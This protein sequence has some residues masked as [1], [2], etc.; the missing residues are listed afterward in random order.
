MTERSSR[1]RRLEDQVARVAQCEGSIGVLSTGEQICV[2]LVLNR[3]DLLPGGYTH[4]LEAVDRLDSSDLQNAV[5]VLRYGSW[6]GR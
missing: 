6:G 3:P 4:I 2:A 5:E 1:F